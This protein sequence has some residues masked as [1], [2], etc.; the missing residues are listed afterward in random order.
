MEKNGEV[1]KKISIDSAIDEVIQSRCHEL[2][3][4]EKQSLKKVL[5]KKIIKLVDSFFEENPDSNSARES[6]NKAI[7]EELEGLLE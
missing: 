2:N 1:D 7:T 6:I 4:D 5:M 3:E